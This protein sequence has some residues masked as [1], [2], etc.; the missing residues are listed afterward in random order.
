M[1]PVRYELQIIGAGI[2]P[3]WCDIR[4]TEIRLTE[5]IGM[6]PK[7]NFV[8]TCTFYGLIIFGRKVVE[9]VETILANMLIFVKYRYP[10]KE[11]LGGGEERQFVLFEIM[12]LR[13]FLMKWRRN[14]L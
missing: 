3:E 9:A 10:D 12:N 8:V 11:N 1:R 7:A 6:F 5:W 4:L 2:A 14:G 13:P